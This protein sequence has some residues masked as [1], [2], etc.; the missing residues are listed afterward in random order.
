M[1]GIKGTIEEL[2]FFLPWLGINLK[3]KEVINL[4]K[5]KEKINVKDLNK[6]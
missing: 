4:I 6:W 3:D 2:F 5:A 1:L